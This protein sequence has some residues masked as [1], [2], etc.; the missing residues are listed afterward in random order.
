M[1]PVPCEGELQNH[2]GVHGKHS[3]AAM[4]GFVVHVS[5]L[6]TNANKTLPLL[7]NELPYAG[8]FVFFCL[9]PHGHK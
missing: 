1:Y 6:V 8:C 4:N 9:Q 2:H 7:A 3:D 5:A